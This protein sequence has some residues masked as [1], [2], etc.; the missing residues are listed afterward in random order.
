MK[1]IFL[2]SPKMNLVSKV[3]PKPSLTKIIHDTLENEKVTLKSNK[4]V[5]FSKFKFNLDEKNETSDKK[6]LFL[7]TSQLPLKD[8]KFNNR[9][10][11]AN[12][13]NKSRK[14]SVLSSVKHK[15]SE[16]LIDSNTLLNNKI[17]KSIFENNKPSIL[18][19]T[20]SQKTIFT[21]SIN[22]N[23][24]Y[25]KL[26]LKNKLTQVKEEKLLNILLPTVYS[27]DYKIITYKEDSLVE[28]SNIYMTNAEKK[29]AEYYNTKF[30]ESI[31]TDQSKFKQAIRTK[32]VLKR[33][34]TSIKPN[35]NNNMSKINNRVF[36]ND[37]NINIEKDNH[38]FRMLKFKKTYQK[39]VK[40]V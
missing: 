3:D 9:L 2:D 34:Q 23:E 4:K 11:S 28:N 13:K 29:E 19:K 14:D 18:K 15:E 35:K 38:L 5:S 1:Q 17:N 25:N 16:I 37:I 33:P 12:I 39:Y 21:N 8:F 6:S 32:P 31:S 20:S 7:T 24:R 40:I 27:Y 22:T 10:I 30:L 26:I 36:Y